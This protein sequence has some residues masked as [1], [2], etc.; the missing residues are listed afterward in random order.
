[1]LYDTK[2]FFDES[3][4]GF[5]QNVW[6]SFLGSLFLFYT[7]KFEQSHAF[8]PQS[9]QSARLS[10]Q[11]SKLAPPHPLTRKGVL[12]PPLWVE[13]GGTLAW[14]EGLGGPNSETGPSIF[15]F[16]NKTDYTNKATYSNE[17]DIDTIYVHSDALK[18]A[19]LK[20]LFKVYQSLSYTFHLQNVL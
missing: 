1:M 16:C 14:G 6:I 13:E 15:F 19:W 9:I 18:D 17:K 2:F 7:S 3:I 4:M 10:F 5:K 11:L 8:L 12:L 20:G